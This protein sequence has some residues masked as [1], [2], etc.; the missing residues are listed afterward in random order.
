MEEIDIIDADSEP[1]NYKDP[2]ADYDERYDDDGTSVRIVNQYPNIPSR[3]R[4]IPD[5]RYNN[6][7]HV[8]EETKETSEEESDQ[9]SNSLR[10]DW[11]ENHEARF[12]KWVMDQKRIRQREEHR[13]GESD[14]IPR[15]V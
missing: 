14:V 6:Y 2:N 13:R 9:A 3:R 8:I 11:D 15:K 5:T 10:M 7:S 4:E 12:V 1:D